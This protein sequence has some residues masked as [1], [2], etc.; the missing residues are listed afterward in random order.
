MSRILALD[1]GARRTGMAISGPDADW[2]FGRGVVDGDFSTLVSAIEKC[3]EREDVDLIVVGLPRSLRGHPSEQEAIVRATV[4]RLREQVT[5]P[6]EFEE[7]R[8]TT[9]LSQR[10]QHESGKSGGDDEQAAI[11]ILESY[12]AKRTSA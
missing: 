12:L 1:L 6:I 10:L 7:E 2:A 5:V 3:I 9:D 8:L 4:D 11:L